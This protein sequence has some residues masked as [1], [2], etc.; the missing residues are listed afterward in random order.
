MQEDTHT[1]SRCGL[2]ATI[3]KANKFR[4]S[5]AKRQTS[6]D[7]VTSRISSPDMNRKEAKRTRTR[8]KGGGARL[9]GGGGG[10]AREVGQKKRIKRNR[11][12]K[13]RTGRQGDRGI[14]PPSLLEGFV[15]GEPLPHPLP[16]HPNATLTH[17]WDIYPEKKK[18]DQMGTP[19]QRT[20]SQIYS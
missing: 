2:A 12:S 20:F 16:S 8:V 14:L 10:E 6:V 7:L 19:F 18:K 13:K 1:G 11:Q 3:R 4:W 5:R 15:D 17:T 9:V